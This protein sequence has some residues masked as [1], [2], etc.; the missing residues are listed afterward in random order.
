MSHTPSNIKPSEYSPFLLQITI[1]SPKGDPLPNVKIDLWHANTDGEYGYRSY[2]LRGRF[3]T[4][5]NGSVEVLTIT[6]GD[7]GAGGNLRTGHFHMMIQ[8]GEGKYDHLT[9]QLY[10]CKGNDVSGMKKDLYV[11]APGSIISRY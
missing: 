8:D 2:A 1:R 3:T 10:V 6:P 5:A 7:Y 9:T 11:I 4:D